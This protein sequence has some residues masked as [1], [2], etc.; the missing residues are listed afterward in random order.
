MDG[1]RGTAFPIP[2]RLAANP[3]LYD[4]LHALHFSSSGAVEMLD[5][6]GQSLNTLVKGRF[7]VQPR[8]QSSSLVHFF[9]LLEVQD[10]PSF[11]LQP[12]DPTASD[13]SD[14][15]EYVLA[16]QPGQQEI[17]VRSLA[18]LSVIVTREEGIFPFMRQVVWK[19]LDKKEWPCLLYRV[20]YVFEVDPLEQMFSNRAGNL[21]YHLEAAEP[22]TRYYYN[23]DDAQ[24]LTVQQLIQMGISIT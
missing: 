10:R 22:D 3:H 16:E 1:E 2:G 12:K 11:Q 4:Y 19:I 7:S 15:S 21:Y 20:R 13:H 24:E 23:Q 14:Y 18:P 6:A 9:D 17:P 8:D 5:G